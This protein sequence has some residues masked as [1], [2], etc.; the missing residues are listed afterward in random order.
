MSLSICKGATQQGKLVVILLNTVFLL[1]VCQLTIGFS[2]F[3]LQINRKSANCTSKFLFV[4]LFY[5]QDLDENTRLAVWKIEENE[6]FFLAHVSVQ[7]E[8]THPN[9][10]LQHLAAR[11]LL[12]YLFPDF[13]HRQIEIAS[14]RKPFLRDDRYH[15]SISHCSDYAAVIVSPVARVGIDVEYFTPRVHKIKHKF[16]HADE[17]RF[18]NAQLPSQQIE[19]LTLLWSAKEAM[20][21]WY[22]LGEVDFSE[23][24]QTYPFEAANSGTI[25][26]FFYKHPFQQKL[27]LSF[28]H[29][30]DICLVWVKSK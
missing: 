12:K 17:L 18:A 7:R 14:S 3:G 22:G 16:L 20:Y 25:E 10:R 27:S 23:M 9:K 8:I 5:Q 29:W 30:D 15:F 19:V 21:K 24:M 26:G 2:A 13:P 28:I 1:F 6:D 4:P 11:Y